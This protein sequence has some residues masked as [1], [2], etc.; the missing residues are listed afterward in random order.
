MSNFDEQNYWEAPK[1]GSTP[2]FQH[3]AGTRPAVWTWFVVYCVVMMLF[4]LI[5]VGLG[6]LILFLPE[7]DPQAEIEP[8]LSILMS[9][10]YI[11]LGL[12]FLIPYLL[13]L[14]LPKKPWVWVF[15]LI[16]ICLGF[17]NCCTIPASIAL[18]IFWIK[19]ETQ[20]FFGKGVNPPPY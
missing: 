3:P 14:F 9:G 1:A 8:E 2:Q 20:A 18:L 5:A 4:A 6:V 19:P 17:T 12:V 13:A 15:D 7:L 16:L 11:V 10:V